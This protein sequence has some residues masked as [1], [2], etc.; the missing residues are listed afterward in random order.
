MK[1]V[2]IIGGITAALYWYVTSQQAAVVPAVGQTEPATNMP[3]LPGGGTVLISGGGE[4]VG[5]GGG[6]GEIGGGQEY[7]EPQWYRSPFDWIFA[8]AYASQPSY[9]DQYPVAP[10][11]ISV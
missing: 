1:E 4:V 7:R 10:G 11:V 6:P 8:Q 5:S 2:L 3:L 9:R